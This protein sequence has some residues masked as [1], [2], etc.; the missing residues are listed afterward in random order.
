MGFWSSVGNLVLKAGSAA[1]KEGKEAAERS[2]Q[3][4]E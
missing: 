4:K 2:S 3:Y 1:L